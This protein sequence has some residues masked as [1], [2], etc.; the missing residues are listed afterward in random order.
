MH[1][2]IMLPKRNGGFTLIETLLYLG[3]LGIFMGGVLVAAFAIIETSGRNQ[4]QITMQEEV[5]FMLG[6]LHWLLADA[7]NITVTGQPPEVEGNRY[8]GTSN[9]F[10]ISAQAGHLRLQEGA[11]LALDLNSDDV[12]VVSADFQ[13]I[14]KVG[15]RPEGVTATVMVQSKTSSGAVIEQK[16]QVTEYLQK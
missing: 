14:P 11:G 16:Y 3:L 6:K 8:G 12:R 2:S 10:V 13:D 5:G 4:T 7:Q 9:P 15:T 1:T